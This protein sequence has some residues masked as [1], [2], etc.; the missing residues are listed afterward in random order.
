MLCV[1][2][3]LV[4]MVGKKWGEGL[5]LARWEVG[6]VPHQHLHLDLSAGAGLGYSCAHHS[7]VHA[8]VKHQC[9]EGLCRAV[10]KII[11]AE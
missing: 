1:R 5:T 6:A 7:S 9:K 3:E 8:C 2:E 4:D 10:C 11:K